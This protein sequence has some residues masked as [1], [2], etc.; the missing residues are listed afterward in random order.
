MLKKLFLGIGVVLPAFLAVKSASAQYVFQ[1]RHGTKTHR[2]LAFEGIQLPP[3]P[4]DLTA[5]SYGSLGAQ[6]TAV[7]APGTKLQGRPWYLTNNIV[8]SPAIASDGKAR[9]CQNQPGQYV[10]IPRNTNAA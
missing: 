5:A 4:I 2:L 10:V 8:Q 9:F 7:T 6:P 3:N 1:C